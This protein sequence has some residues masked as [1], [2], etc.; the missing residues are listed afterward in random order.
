MIPSFYVIE[1]E[2]EKKN[3]FLSFCVCVSA[4]CVHDGKSI[5][6]ADVRV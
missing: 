4:A 5:P 1:E 2:E 3:K 6:R